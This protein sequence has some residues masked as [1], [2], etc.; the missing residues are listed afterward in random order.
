MAAGLATLELYDQDTVDRVN[1][2]GEKLRN[3]VNAAFKSAGMTGQATGRGSL[4][5]IHWRLGEINNAM[6]SVEGMFLAGDLPKYL[7]LELMNRGYYSA[8]RGM[9]V[10]STPMD[11]GVID[12]FLEALAG[13][14]EVLKPYVEGKAPHLLIE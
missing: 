11:E 6:D 4:A 1:A 12:G 7:H 8:P 9:L 2:L 3:G 10:I 14:L 13:A 5:Q